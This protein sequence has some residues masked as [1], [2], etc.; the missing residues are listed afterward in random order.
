MDRVILDVPCSGSGVWR[1][2]PELKWRL[3]EGKLMQYCRIQKNL[4]S[5]AWGFVKPGGRMIYMTCSLFHDENEVQVTEFMAGHE[6]AKL[7]PYTDFYKRAELKTLS[8]LPECLALSPYTHSTD[9]F[10]V[11]ILEKTA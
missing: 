4:L 7:V 2:N 5:E 3:D 9:G 1:R 11:A 6:N 8:S 10:F